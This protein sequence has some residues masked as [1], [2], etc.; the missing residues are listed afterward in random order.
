M[1]GKCAG[2]GAGVQTPMTRFQDGPAKGK[3]LMLKRAPRFLRVV[4]DRKGGIDALDQLEDVPH[5]HE[6]IHAY[7]MIGERGMCHVNMGRGR[8]GFYSFANYALCKTQPSDEV[9]RCNDD[10]RAWC[11]AMRDAHGS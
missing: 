11:E 6:T 8:G 10:W 1:G 9:L 4:E 7:E 3:T 5:A 2:V